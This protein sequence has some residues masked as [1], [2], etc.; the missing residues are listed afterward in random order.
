MMKKHIMAALTMGMI[1]AGDDPIYGIPRRP[2]S[3][4]QNSP[5]KPIKVQPKPTKIFR[6]HGIEI[7][8]YSKKDAIKRYNHKYKINRR[9]IEVIP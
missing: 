1:M 8:A 7:E 5:A 9:T 3:N 4:T 2:R 6:V